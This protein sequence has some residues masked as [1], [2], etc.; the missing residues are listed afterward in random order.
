MLQLSDK[1]KAWV[2]LALGSNITPRR[3]HILKAVNAL[4]ELFPD[5]FEVSSV[6]QTAP[7]LNRKQLAYLNSCVRFQIQAEPDSVLQ[8]IQQIEADLGRIR[9]TDKF[10]SRT[11]DIDILLFGNRIVQTD[12]LTI[13][14]YDMCN[15]DFM[16]IPL[17]ELAPD[18]IHPFTGIPFKDDLDKI[19]AQQKTY[20]KK[21]PE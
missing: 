20:P 16:L 6:Y 12:S 14:H 13:P 4:K 2:Y 1:L 8:K 9:S 10:Q 17:L 21:L 15:R 3:I 5:H 18:L 11:I 19:P 7:Y